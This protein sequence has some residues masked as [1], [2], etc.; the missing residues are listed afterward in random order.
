MARSK[1]SLGLKALQWF[2]TGIEFCCAAVIL[3]IFCYFLATLH[4][5]HLSIS[6]Y[7]RAVTGISGAA[8]VFTIAGLIFLCCVGG[9]AVFALIALILDIGFTGAFIY[10]AWKTRGGAHSCRGYVNTPFGSG[11]AN[12]N[13]QI[14]APDGGVTALPSLHTACELEKACFAVAIIAII[15][16]LLSAFVELLL[17]KNHRKEKRFGPSPG[18]NYTAGTGRRRFWQRKSRVGVVPEKNANALPLHTT[19]A[20]A[21]RASY[22][23]DA[24]AVG[25]QEPGY[26]G[27]NKYGTGAPVS[28][29]YVAPVGTAV[30][31]GQTTT[32]YPQA[33]GGVTSMPAVGHHHGANPAANY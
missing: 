9:I 6:T 28:D 25:A 14:T 27:Y 8:V 16:F 4:D 10:V 15:F 19:P 18:N 11:E 5:H 13:K 3:A 20:E 1:S 2:L 12:T 7:V 26:N 22:A 21:T 33:Q 17:M 23:T 24:T 29:G 32:P 31:H 30:G